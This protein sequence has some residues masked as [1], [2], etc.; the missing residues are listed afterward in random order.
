VKAGYHSDVEGRAYCLPCIPG[1]SSSEDGMDV[2]IQCPS[3]WIGDIAPSKR[4]LSCEKGKSSSI[5]SSS[6]T[7]CPKGKYGQLE[8]QNHRVCRDCFPGYFGSDAGT[9]SCQLCP[10][11]WEQTSPGVTFC[12]DLNWKQP[13]DCNDEQY[14]N[15]TDADG[16]NWKCLQCP[17]GTSCIGAVLW[18]NVTAL[19]GY[20]RCPSTTLIDSKG[21]VFER[22]PWKGAC[23]GTANREL[24]GKYIDDIGAKRNSREGCHK[25]YKN[26]SKLC[27]NC[28]T[29][30]SH[31]ADL[32]GQCS[33]CPDPSQ[34]IF[35]LV[36]ALFFCL[37]GI[38]TYIK[39]TLQDAGSLDDGSGIRA[40]ALSY[41]QLISLLA[42]FPVAWPGIFSTI[43]Y[44]GG[45]VAVLGSSIVDQ[46]CLLN[47]SEA[48]VFYVERTI[49]SILP[50]FL[51]I[52]CSL[53]WQIVFVTSCGRQ[54][55]RRST[56]HF[57]L[58]E[59][60]MTLRLYT[61]ASIVALYQ[62]IWPNL[63]SQTFSIFSCQS[64]CQDGFQYLRADLSQKCWTG[65]H[66]TYIFCIGIPS[67][68][69]YVFGFPLIATLAILRMRNRVFLRFM[70]QS[71]NRISDVSLKSA[72]SARRRALSKTQVGVQN[73]FY[74]EGVL[75][76]KGHVSWGIFYSMFRDPVWWWDGTIAFRKI[77][78]AFIGVFGSDLSLM[79]VHIT[80]LFVLISILSTAIIRPFAGDSPHILQATELSSLAATWLTLWAF[81]VFEK[82]P[83]CEEYSESFGSTII[84]HEW[85]NILSIFVGVSNILVLIFMLIAFLYV[86]LGEQFF[87][88]NMFKTITTQHSQSTTS[89][90]ATLHRPESS[91][92]IE[93]ITNPSSN[94]TLHRPERSERPERIDTI[95]NP[96][97]NPNS[98]PKKNRKK[99][100]KIK[101]GS[102][103]VVSSTEQEI[104]E[105]FE[106]QQHQSKNR[107]KRNKHRKV[108]MTR[109]NI[110][111]SIGKM[112]NDKRRRRKKVQKR[113]CANEEKTIDIRKDDDQPGQGV[114]TDDGDDGATRKHKFNAIAT[115]PAS[116][117]K[118][119]RH[120]KTK[121][122][123]KN[124]EALSEDVRK[125]NWYYLDSADCSVE[126]TYSQLLII[127]HDRDDDR[128]TADT[129][130]WSAELDCEWTEL[131]NLTPLKHLLMVDKEH[132]DGKY[133]DVG[134]VDEKFDLYQNRWLVLVDNTD[135]E[136]EE[137]DEK[138]EIGEAIKNDETNVDDG[139]DI[140]RGPYSVAE[141]RNLYQTREINDS[142]LVWAECLDDWLSIGEFDQMRTLLQVAMN[143]SNPSMLNENE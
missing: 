43:F 11:G 23:L 59:D 29:N 117:F 77:L 103:L 62:L 13:R 6:C 68:I 92:H 141:L 37:A 45:Q 84:N 69:L 138:G 70:R 100:R 10:S 73:V 131:R 80:M 107:S 8:N 143:A 116:A 65:T 3:G 109:T 63:C 101:M 40:I 112:K 64:V 94:E 134:L 89:T 82:Y 135:D 60:K 122:K 39:I 50:I 20:W 26:K 87:S 102:I 125:M 36:M 38:L 66:Q 12:T 16:T 142:T 61:R 52:C 30:Y 49:W 21:A 104:N 90:N 127:Y 34:N 93:M 17:K 5:G 95:T 140:H 128:I 110:R 115:L 2:C 136:I 67:M 88:C 129:L 28:G 118:E 48:E 98:P 123:I 33:R 132:L 130:C 18:R 97:R 7:N 44:V 27:S 9:E 78:V 47:I 86:K 106:R 19:T 99:I 108:Q 76:T 15:N 35:L 96:L 1:W 71:E 74:I 14:L 55:L 83:R 81:S 124:D 31:A 111:H 46:K 114:M 42:S 120:K 56:V 25:G 24:S 139:T 72:Q 137:N 53:G 121:T 51:Y 79:Q 126:V 54:K 85:C 113:I 4:C 119:N 133:A 22:C 57:S 58:E 75:K 91:A 32:T 105:I 41:L